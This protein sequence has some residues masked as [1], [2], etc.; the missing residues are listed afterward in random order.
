[1]KNSLKSAEAKQIR[2]SINNQKCEIALK[3]GYKYDESTGEIIG[4]RGKVINAKINGYTVISFVDA[5]VKQF[6][7]ATTFIEY[8]LKKENDAVSK[9]ELELAKIFVKPSIAYLAN[10]KYL[11]Q[12]K[13]LNE[14]N[15]M[16]VTTYQLKQNLSMKDYLT[17]DKTLNQRSSRFSKRSFKSRTNRN[18]VIL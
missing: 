11:Q 12:S 18:V 8:V 10:R 3:K 9:G 16:V 2:L 15:F 5:G 4:V 14:P 13:E 6:L 17:K 1:M 7:Y